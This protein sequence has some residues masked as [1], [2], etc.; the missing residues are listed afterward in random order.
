V[1]KYWIHKTKIR[2]FIRYQLVEQGTFF[3]CTFIN[4]YRRHFKFSNADQAKLEALLWL[5]VRENPCKPLT[6]HQLF[7]KQFGFKVQPQFL[8][9]IF[10]RWGWRWKK[11]V[12]RQ[13]EKYSMQNI[14]KYLCFLAGVSDIPMERLKFLDEAHFVSKDLHRRQAMGEPGEPVFVITSAKLDLS[15]SL[16]LLTSL[17]DLQHS[18]VIDLRTNSNTQWDFASFILFCLQNN[19]LTAGDYLILDNARYARLHCIF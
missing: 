16:T 14:E 9:K 7:L 10:Q 13:I 17:A 8:G 18:C 15:Y 3:I 1:V 6:M 19:H 5:S 11:P 12:R 4:L 2:R